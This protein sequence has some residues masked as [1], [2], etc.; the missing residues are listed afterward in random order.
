ME[1]V[2]KKLV[3]GAKN[4]D[5]QAFTELIN[6]YKDKIYNHVYRIIGNIQEAEDI[7]QETFLKVYANIDKYDEQYKFSTWIY[8]IA[9]NLCIDRIRRKKADFSLDNKW[10]EEDGMDWYNKLAAPDMTPEEEVIS[11][12]QHKQ[13]EQAILSLPPKYRVVMNLRYIQDFSIQEIS[14]IVNLSVATVK[15]RLFRGRESLRKQLLENGSLKERSGL[16]EM[17]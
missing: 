16:Y 17:S 7:T 8:R 10:E 11:T 3:T 6:L 14:K 1:I 15:T 13:V 5:K 9:T 2:D 12:E 4:G